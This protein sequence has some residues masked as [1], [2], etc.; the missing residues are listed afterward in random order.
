MESARYV[1]KSFI[2]LCLVL[3]LTGKEL[4]ISQLLF[5]VIA[6]GKIVSNLLAG[7]IAQSSA[8]QAGDLMQDLKTGMLSAF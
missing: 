1:E 8:Q 3:A 7:A 6:P 5:G 2:I 4:Q